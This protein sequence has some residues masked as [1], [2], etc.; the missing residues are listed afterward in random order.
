MATS[1]STTSASAKVHPSND[2]PELDPDSYAL[3]KFKLY[4]TRAVSVTHPFNS[5]QPKSP[6]EWFHI[7]ISISFSVCLFVTEQ[8][9]YLIGSDRNKRFFRVLK[10]DR[11]EP[12]DLNISQDPVLY[13]PQEIKSLLQ[14][15]AEGNRATGGLTFVAKVFGIAG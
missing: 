12:S 9:F 5:I 1:A 6:I 11:S 8:R 15:I 7:F 2:P 3:E 4:E 14:R 10:I 13:S